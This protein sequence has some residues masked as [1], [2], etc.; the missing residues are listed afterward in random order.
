MSIVWLALTWTMTNSCLVLLWLEDAPAKI[1]KHSLQVPHIA[2]LGWLF[3]MHEDFLLP[4]F[5]L[6]LHN[7]V[8]T[9]APNQ[10]LKSNL[11]WHINQSM[12]APLVKKE[13]KP[14]TRQIG[15]P[16]GSHSRNST[17]FQSLFEESIAL[18]F[19]QIIYKS[20]SSTHSNLA[21]ENGIEQKED[22]KRAIA[23]DTTIL[24]L[25]LKTFSLKIL[26]INCPLPSLNNVTLCT[27]LMAVTTLEGKKLFLLVDPTWNGQGFNIS[28][29][30][31]YAAQ[32]H[33]FVEYL[34]A[35]LAHSHGTEVYHWFTPDAVAEAQAMGWDNTKNQP[36]SPD[37]LDLWNTL[38]SLDL[39]WCVVSPT[40]A[41]TTN[42][43]AV[44]LD[45]I[46]LPSF[47]TTTQQPAAQPGA[48]ST[49]LAT[50]QHVSTMAC[51]CGNTSWS[52]CGFHHGY[53]LVSPRTH[54]YPSSTNLAEAECHL[55][56]SPNFYQLWVYLNPA[57]P[58]LLQPQ[59]CLTM[60]QA[61]GTNSHTAMG[62]PFLSWGFP[63]SPLVPLIHLSQVESHAQTINHHSCQLI[64]TTIFMSSYSSPI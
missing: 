11:T 55:S 59:A 63:T 37:D 46:M 38:Q 60:L 18:L 45:N 13:V 61:R 62:N 6:L 54:V 10:L 27:T 3:G 39:E 35:Y 58:H 32:A 33:N 50:V 43:V 48:P 7:T 36:I 21:K 9:L 15:S 23:H 14:L 5:K 2:S 42:A 16:C 22:I 20:P 8:K 52:Y 49:A 47:N 12:M 19:Y 1:Y 40:A 28:Y 31:I 64:F 4:T 24:Q 56:P 51:I 53:P 25:I 17:Y 26:S 30:T 34:P 41:S 29:P 57:S 44:D